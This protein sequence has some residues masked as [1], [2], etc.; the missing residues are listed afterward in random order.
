MTTAAGWF[1]AAVAVYAL[2]LLGLAL[3]ERQMLFPAHLVVVPKGG[4]PDDAESWWVGAD[5][6]QSEAWFFSASGGKG[7]APLP[8]AVIFHGNGECI[9]QTAPLARWYSEYQGY[10]RSDGDPS[11]QAIVADAAAHLARRG[12]GRCVPSAAR[13]RR[14]EADLPLRPAPPAPRFCRLR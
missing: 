11:Q 14:E 2:W 4:L 1:G 3:T 9:D 12:A 8:A 13:C 7:G 6:E 5:G 10:G